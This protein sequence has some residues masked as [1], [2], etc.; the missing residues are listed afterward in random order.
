MPEL[1]E[2]EALRRSLDEPITTAP[3]E[4]AG[5]A[6]L[7]TLKTAEPPL[8]TLEGRLLAGARRRG[9]RL[10]FP[11]ADGE[12]VLVVHLMS[13]G[14]LR[15]LSAKE[16]RPAAPAFRLRFQDDAELVLSEPGKRKRAGVW[17]LTPQAA[18]SQLSHLGPDALELDRATLSGVCG[19]ER[20]R[21]Y[22]FLRD[23]RVVA[24]IGRAWANEILHAARLSPFALAG[25]LDGRQ[26]ER[27]DKAIHDEL[28]RGIELRERGQ[29]DERVYRVH[30]RLGLPCHVCGTPIARVAYEEHTIFYCRYCQ[31]GGRPL[32]DR[33][34]SRLLR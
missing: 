21:L 14:R 26:L 7:A 10:L 34:L 2:V 28:E 4:R 31:T 9:K 8:A 32:A 15:L 27:L 13:A 6:H 17:L 30:G 25:E 33:R 22:G 1:P 5:P 16:R 20:R 23:Q 19:G 18:E 3:I 11:T 29:A 12:L 24:G